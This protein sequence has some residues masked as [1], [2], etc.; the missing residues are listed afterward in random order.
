MNRTEVITLVG[1]FLK[2]NKDKY[3][4]L[5][6]LLKEVS[7]DDRM[8]GFKELMTMKPFSEYDLTLEDLGDF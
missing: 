3:D 5:K 6:E 2:E 1:E 4:S 8:E 7:P